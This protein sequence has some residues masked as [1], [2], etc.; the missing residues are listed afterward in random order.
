MRT[1]QWLLGLTLLSTSAVQAQPEN[2]TLGEVALTPP[3]CQDVQGIPV[4]GWSQH[5]RESPNA[6]YWVG[7]MGNTFWAM[8]HYCWALI[9][10]QRAE[11]VALPAHVRAHMIRSAIND[12]YYVVNHAN[13]HHAGGSFVLMPE[14]YFRIGDAHVQLGEFARAIAAFDLSQRAKVDYW[15]P[16]LGHAEVLERLGQRKQA[17][18]ILATGLRYNPDEPKLI[19]AYKRLGGRPQDVKPLIRPADTATSA[20]Q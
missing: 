9:H 10:L 1:R 4:I 14:L 16:Y 6:P 13:R 8:H 15:P 20:P 7:I 19:A 12:F 3:V 2:M 18:E 17:R 5:Y 11:R